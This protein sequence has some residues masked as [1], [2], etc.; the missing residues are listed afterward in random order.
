ML[1][2][3][4]AGD[5]EMRH[6]DIMHGNKVPRLRNRKAIIVVVPVM[7]RA[8]RIKEIAGMFPLTV[9]RALL[10]ASFTAARIAKNHL[11]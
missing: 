10:I 1:V 4:A 11:L 9:K 3:D 8:L 2:V 6:A 5:D 7:R